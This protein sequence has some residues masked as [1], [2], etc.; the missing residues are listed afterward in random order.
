[1]FSPYARRKNHRKKNK[2]EYDIPPNSVGKL[3][4][5]SE[6]FKNFKNGDYPKPGQIKIRRLK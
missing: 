2:K 3:Y 6:G 5:I 1:M 4:V